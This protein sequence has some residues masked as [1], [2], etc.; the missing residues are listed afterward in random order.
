MLTQTV[1][2]LSFVTMGI[3][4]LM[5]IAIPL[6]LFIFYRKKYDCK[7]KPFITGCA[8]FAVFALVLEGICHAIIL[9]GGRQD[10]ITAK[11]LLYALY[12]GLMAGL[13]E[14]T[15]RFIAFKTVLKDSH[16]TDNTALMYGAGHG[17][18]EAF[19][20]LFVSG[21]SNIIMAVLINSGN[22]QLLTTGLTA[23][24]LAAIQQLI[25]TLVTTKPLAYCA[26]IVERIPAVAFHISLSVIVWFAVKNKEKWYLYPL[27]IILHLVLDA[28]TAT[29]AAYK[30]N[31]VL[32][33]AFIYVFAIAIIFLALKIWRKNSGS[34]SRVDV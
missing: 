16:D 32:I 14:E 6:G 5:G 11:P 25:D 19:Y 22:T 34:N 15:G 24:K 33:E 20:I 8:I 13:F 26:G 2:A 3:T 1:P 10:L 12:G 23:D 27:A 29:L 18:F 21:V 31:V 30:V 9:G 4:L 28:A 7:I 17:G